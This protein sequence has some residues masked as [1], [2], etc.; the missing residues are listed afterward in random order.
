M[1][2]QALT[3]AGV[4]NVPEWWEAGKVSAETSGISLNALLGAQL[5]LCGFV[6]AKRWVDI[7]KPGSQGEAGSFVGLEAGFKGKGPYPGACDG[8]S[9]LLK[10]CEGI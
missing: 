5:I 8:G 3:K 7:L 2:P 6:E 4:L 1:S 9:S 10:G